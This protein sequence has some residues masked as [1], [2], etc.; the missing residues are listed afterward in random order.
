MNAMAAAGR[1][2]RWRAHAVG[3]V[4]AK[5]FTRT[6]VALIL[7]N[8]AILGLE[9][10]PDLDARHRSLLA[11]A[12]RLILAIFVGELCVRI[13]AHGARFFRDPWSLFDAATVSIALVPA[14]EA[15]SVL[16]ALRVLRVLRL[17]SAFP[18]LRRVVQGLLSAIPS[19]GS[20][21][22]ILV[23]LLYVFAVIA[24]KLFGADYPQWF[25]GLH[26]SLFTL[27]QVMTLEGWPDI[28]RAVSATHP[29][30]WV[31]FVIY[32]LLA[33]FTVL[34]FF[35][36]VIVDAMQKTHESHD[37]RMEITLDRIGKNIEE[38]NSR[39]TALAA[40]LPPSGEAARPN[41]R[42]AQLDGA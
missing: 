24:A 22:A 29:Y 41:R 38:L 31:F 36:A 13:F 33:T 2:S 14:N 21:T 1:L 6:I 32:I 39:L 8:A 3:L 12:D 40:A 35:I 17:V 30:A 26:R 27:F 18:Q 19:L 16:R 20:I 10:L 28:V 4:E 25:G 11:A 42:P 5:A 7:I 15:F 23:V 37:D 9:T 34:N